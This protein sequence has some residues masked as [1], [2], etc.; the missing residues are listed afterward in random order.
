[1]AKEVNKPLKLAISGISSN[2][3]MELEK[4]GAKVTGLLYL[5]KGA[6]SDDG[7]H[8]PFA[9]FKKCR[10]LDESTTDV[11]AHLWSALEKHR[12]DFYRCFFRWPWSH[13]LISG[14]GDAEG[15]FLNAVRNCYRWLCASKPDM[16]VF[17]NVPHEG[18][19]VVLYEVAKAMNLPTLVFWQG[20][21]PG[22][23]WVFDHWS[24]LGR[25]DSSPKTEPF[26]VDLSEPEFRP[27]YMAGIQNNRRLQRQAKLDV[28][29][30]GFKSLGYALL[31]GERRLAAFRRNMAKL[32]LAR[33]NVFYLRGRDDRFSRS[34]E[35]LN[36]KKF[37][38][39]PL[40]LEPEMEV[41]KLGGK[42][43]NQVDVVRRLREKLPEDVIIA[44]KDNPKQDS[45]KRSAAF[46]DQLDRIPNVVL[47]NS[48]TESW[49][50]IKRS[51]ATATICGTAGWEA[52]RIGKPVIVFGYAFWNR[53]PGAYRIDDQWE[54]A[55][56]EGYQKDDS[57][58]E[59]AVEEVSK[60]AWP[61]IVDH[62]YVR[63]L[64]HFDPVQN[65]DNLAKAI[66][67]FAKHN[68]ISA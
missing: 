44:V 4:H 5:R 23:M 29:T 20:V 52:L 35:E 41:D 8:W 2:D 53:L 37:V 38:Y 26:P 1:M 47:V 58:F 33:E 30:Y 34:L 66:L 13:E 50:L 11:P 24:D 18:A 36:E 62:D 40:H 27:F 42:Y 9:E 16:V 46:F 25:F 64:D 59:E 49:E 45:R 31:S 10:W 14:F 65:A 3:A 63:S 15:L 43:G 6:P 32:S 56:I 7:T 39:Y 51:I 57:L 54:F 28:F 19:L 67:A 68:D 55:E 48:Q 17:S 12:H 61:G 60:N 21:I 22:R